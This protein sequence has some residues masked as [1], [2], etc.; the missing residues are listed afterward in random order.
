MPATVFKRLLSGIICAIIK[1]QI[2]ACN[3]NFMK[4]DSIICFRVSKELHESLAHIAHADRRSLSS[5]IEMIL[6]T[7]LIGKKTVPGLEMRRYP[8]KPVEIP[9]VI[10]REEFE[11]SGRGSIAD[12]SLGGVRILIPKDLAQN[13]A[14]DSKGSKFN[15]IFDL[16]REHDPVKITC[17]STRVDDDGD[18]IVVGAS[19]IDAEFKS[20]QSLQ[21]YLM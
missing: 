7:Y 5:M 13:V 18:N 17:E 8:R 2:F 20:Y 21:T 1:N 6:S 15:I 4:K 11:Q 12:I 16:P 3:E 10:S 19:F 14:V 9:T